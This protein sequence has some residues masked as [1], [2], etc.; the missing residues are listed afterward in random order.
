MAKLLEIGCDLDDG[1]RDR[2]RRALRE[3]IDN[4]DD[5]KQSMKDAGEPLTDGQIEAMVG[6]L[7]DKANQDDPSGDDAIDSGDP[8]IGEDDDTEADDE[9][10]S[11]CGQLVP[12]EDS[13]DDEPDGD[14][15]SL[16]LED[17]TG[18]DSQDVAVGESTRQRAG[19]VYI[20]GDGKKRYIGT[21]T[22]VESGRNRK[23]ESNRLHII[24]I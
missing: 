23:R 6:A 24:R 18:G 20:G 3:A 21:S 9:V 1:P 4:L 10:C 7:S 2:A 11:Q 8:D 13:D 17:L 14:D 22:L 12:P 16:G 5:L 15:D 19:G